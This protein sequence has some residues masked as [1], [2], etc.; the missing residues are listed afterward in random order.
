VLSSFGVLQPCTTAAANENQIHLYTGVASHNMFTFY[1]LL[2]RIYGT[3]QID[4]VWR[5]RYILTEL[6]ASWGDANCAAPKEL[7]SILRNPK[8][9]YLVHKSPPLFPILSHINP[10]HSIPSYLLFILILSA[11]VRLG[12]PSGPF[13]SRFHTNILY[14]FLFSPIRAQCPAHFILLDLITLITLGEGYKLWS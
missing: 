11:H 5:R 3:V 14:A 6:S 8:L 13:P 12:L 9:Q 7:P 4:G 2:R 1:M 10:I